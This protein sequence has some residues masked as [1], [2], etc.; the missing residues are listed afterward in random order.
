M[1]NPLQGLSYNKVTITSLDGKE[2]DLTNSLLSTDYFEDILEPCI[3]ISKCN[4][5]I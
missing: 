2:V 1:A 5:W 3:Y 4:Q